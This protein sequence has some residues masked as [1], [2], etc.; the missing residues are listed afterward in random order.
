[1]WSWVRTLHPESCSVSKEELESI[2]FPHYIEEMIRFELHRGKTILNHTDPSF[3]NQSMGS[4]YAKAEKED[5]IFIEYVPQD[6]L[7]IT[8]TIRIEGIGDYYCDMFR[9]NLERE[10]KGL[11]PCSLNGVR[12]NITENPSEIYRYLVDGSSDFFGIFAK[13]VVLE[14]IKYLK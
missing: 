4:N 3:A 14:N 1:M 13:K 8:Y 2:K 10:S 12:L 9:V 6:L 5:V 7:N 11:P